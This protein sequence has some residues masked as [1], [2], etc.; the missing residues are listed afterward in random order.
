MPSTSDSLSATCE[1]EHSTPLEGFADHARHLANLA[2]SCASAC[3]EDVDR[4]GHIVAKALES[5]HKVL[6]CGNGGSAADAQ[7]FAAELV[8]HYIVGR[9]PLAAVSLTTDTSILTAVGN[10]FGYEEIFARQVEA[11]GQP[12]DVLIVMST[13]GRSPNIIRAAEVALARNLRLIALTGM[14]AHEP[15]SKAEAWCRVPSSITAL[16][17]EMHTVVLHEICALTEEIIGFARVDS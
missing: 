5:G 10:D 15:I 6:A 4:A 1:P 13:S 7:H 2:L 3:H 12:G 14:T 9:P 8:G 11:L 17:Q 16:V